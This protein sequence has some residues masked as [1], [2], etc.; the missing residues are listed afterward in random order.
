MKE[1]T[2][3]GVDLAKSVFTVCEPIARRTP[4]D[5][6]RGCRARLGTATAGHPLAQSISV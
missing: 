1:V 4:L 3:D 2:T 5:R 6:R